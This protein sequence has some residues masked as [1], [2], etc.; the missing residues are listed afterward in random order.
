MGSYW[1]WNTVLRRGQAYRRAEIPLDRRLNGASRLQKTLLAVPIAKVVAAAF[2]FY[3]VNVYSN[4]IDCGT[5]LS[6]L[7][8]VA[9]SSTEVAFH[10]VFFMVAGGFCILRDEFTPEQSNRFKSLILVLYV[11]LSGYYFGSYFS[12]MCMAMTWIYLVTTEFN[13]IKRNVLSLGR[14]LE[15]LVERPNTA[16]DEVRTALTEQTQ[17]QHD[18]LTG[19]RHILTTYLVL[20]VGISIV[21]SG[22]DTI[23]PLGSILQSVVEVATFIVL[24][25]HLSGCRIGAFPY[26]SF[27]DLNESA[28]EESGV[29]ESISTWI[30]KSTNLQLELKQLSNGDLCLGIPTQT[31]EEEEEKPVDSLAMVANPSAVQNTQ[32]VP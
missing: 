26:S 14:A 4:W 10:C 11:S 1:V 20:S 29:D 27:V 25:N 17:K 32:S 24:A 30:H 21:L 15:R 13:F 2:Q 7:T 23:K 22:D 28:D 8:T 16:S 18:L 31:P 5:I 6:M 9:Y 3:T 19:F 12:F